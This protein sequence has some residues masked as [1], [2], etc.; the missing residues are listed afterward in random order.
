MPKINQMGLNKVFAILSIFLIVIGCGSEKKEP[1]KLAEKK[2]NNTLKMFEKLV[3]AQTGIS[4]NN[5]I[6][7]DQELVFYD[8]Q[9]QFNGGG[10]GIA[11]FDNDGLSDVFFAGNEV[12]NKL[13]LNLGELKFE[14]I[15]DKANVGQLG[16]WVSGVTIVDINSDGFQDIY[17][18]RGGFNPAEQRKKQFIN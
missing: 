5:T 8:F 14:D 18:S 7:P 9:Y 15:T 3:A 13:Y 17:L 2:V 12:S 10:V 11:D 6:S 1:A 16:S 4:F